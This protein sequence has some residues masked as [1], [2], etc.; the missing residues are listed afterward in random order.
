MTSR[1]PKGVET[2]VTAQ[3]FL[4]Y[5]DEQTSAADGTYWIP[6]IPR[7]ILILHDEADG[8]LLPFE[9]YMLLSARR[10]GIS[11]YVQVFGRLMASRSL[12]E[13]YRYMQ[14]TLPAGGNDPERL[15]I[16][17]TDPQ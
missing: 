17:R 2:P 3:H 4:T 12:V 8:V 15:A 1:L 9:P 6:R 16:F 7:P 5:W 10:R 11:R 13:F 14:Q